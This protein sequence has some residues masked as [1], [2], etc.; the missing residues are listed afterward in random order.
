MCVNQ[1]FL[2]GQE[3][4]YVCPVC[5]DLELSLYHIKN[6]KNNDFRIFHSISLDRE[7]VLNNLSN[8]PL[9]SLCQPL[10]FNNLQFN[11]FCYN[12]F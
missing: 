11:T 2:F 8:I 4:Q 10:L 9:K 5:S 12:K 3:N 7:I 6:F 1:F